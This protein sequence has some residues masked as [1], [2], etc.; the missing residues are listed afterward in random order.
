MVSRGWERVDWV[1][2]TWVEKLEQAIVDRSL[3][4]ILRKIS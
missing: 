1:K 4:L 2:G 3:G